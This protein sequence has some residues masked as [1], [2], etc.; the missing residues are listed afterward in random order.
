MQE[1]DWS[2]QKGLE[3]ISAASRCRAWAGDAETERQLGELADS[4]AERAMTLMMGGSIGA[5]AGEETEAPTLLGRRQ[6]TRAG[7]G[8][9]CARNGEL[10]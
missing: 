10:W 9:G 3:Y 1:A 2:F 6:Q 8:T 7:W 4:Y 5:S